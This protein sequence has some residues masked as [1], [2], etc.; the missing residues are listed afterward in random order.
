MNP[1]ES[2]PEDLDAYFVSFREV[3]TGPCHRYYLC[4]LYTSDA[5]DE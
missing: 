5:A 3:K 4:L 1:E 2:T